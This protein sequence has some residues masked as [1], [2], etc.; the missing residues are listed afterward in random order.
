MVILEKKKRGFGGKFKKCL[1]IEK[2]NDSGR[3]EEGN[4]LRSK[5]K[6]GYSVQRAISQ[7]GWGLKGKIFLED[8]KGGKTSQ[9]EG[10]EG[11]LEK[12]RGKK[13]LQDIIQP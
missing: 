12:K 11:S 6:K 7:R 3:G 13:F 1:K 8:E 10:E 4:F 9:N 5:N 2:Q